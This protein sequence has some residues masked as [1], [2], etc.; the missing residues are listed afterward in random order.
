MR[1]N[2]T[3]QRAREYACHAGSLDWPDI[4][5]RVIQQ[6]TAWRYAGT[7]PEWLSIGFAAKHSAIA[8]DP[9]QETL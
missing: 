1:K 2:Y 4:A 3:I 6:H 9:N 8:R 5:K 7:R